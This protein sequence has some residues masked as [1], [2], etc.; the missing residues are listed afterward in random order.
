M[1]DLFR[2]YTIGC[3]LA[4]LVAAIG[5]IMFS[6]HEPDYVMVYVGCMAV[7]LV[8]LWLTA[9]IG[10]VVPFE[11]G[12]I[13]ITCLCAIDGILSIIVNIELRI[14]APNDGQLQLAIAV[15]H[16]ILLYIFVHIWV[17]IRTEQKMKESE[18]LWT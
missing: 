4:T 7:L 1:N 17:I 8:S 11:T 13:Y 2:K 18:E 9:L 5:Y 15:P 16:I 6:I 12:L 3:L 10:L 14:L